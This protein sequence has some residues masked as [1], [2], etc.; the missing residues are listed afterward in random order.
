TRSRNAG[1]APNDF[2]LLSGPA[3][4]PWPTD[5]GHLGER[6]EELGQRHS[7]DATERRDRVHGH[8]R[9][10]ALHTAHEHRMKA[11]VVCK[12]LLGEPVVVA[13]FPDPPT[14]RPMEPP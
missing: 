1:R 5:L 8:A 12:P 10:T 14:H 2:E 9:R 7:H 6:L 3:S 13:D 11:R 4:T